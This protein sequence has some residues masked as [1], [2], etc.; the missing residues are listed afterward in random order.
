MAV[1]F[2]SA[3]LCVL[4]VARLNSSCSCVAGAKNGAIT[5][6]IIKLDANP[7]MENGQEYLLKNGCGD[8]CVNFRDCDRLKRI[9]LSM[10]LCTR[11]MELL[12]ILT[13]GTVYTTD[14]TTT[15]FSRRGIGS[16]CPSPVFLEIWTKAVDNTGTCVESGVPYKWWHVA[17]PKATFTLGDSTFENGIATVKLTGYAE[18]NSTLGT[19]CWTANPLPEGLDTT[20]PEIFLLESSDPPATSCG[21]VTVPTLS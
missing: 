19:G 5:S 8:I 6:G 15:G 13:G 16:T 14:S 10:E 11:D 3:K 9:N 17:Y 7:E 2:S 21:Y 4:R 18:A 20:A 12:E 1:C